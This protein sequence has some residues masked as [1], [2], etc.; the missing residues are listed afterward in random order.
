MTSTSKKS[1]PASVSDRSTPALR[2]ALCVVLLGVAACTTRPFQPAPPAYKLWAK[3]GVA[4]QGVRGAMLD[5]G[6]NDAAYVDAT[7]MTTNDVARAELCMIDRGFAYQ[8]RRILC[9]SSPDLPACA[10]VPRGKTFGSDPDFDPAR[11]KSGVQRPPAYTYWSRVGTDVEGVKRAMAACGYT[12]VVEPSQVMLRND[13]AAAQLCMID[14]Q[15]V[16]AAPANALVCRSTPQLSAC[17]NRKI[18]AQR[19]CAA[20]KAAGSQ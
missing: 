5:C 10:G 4:E 15:F 13:L 7:K 1:K 14:Q 3:P 2:I 19:C 9:A 11:L 18:D 8:D 6:Y 12:T 17:H 20:P 16:Y